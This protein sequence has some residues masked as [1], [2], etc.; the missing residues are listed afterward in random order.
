MLKTLVY[1]GDNN[2]ISLRVSNL[3]DYFDGHH[4]LIDFD[5]VQFA[6]DYFQIANKYWGPFT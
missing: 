4:N 3:H 5:V 1:P 2:M 6:I